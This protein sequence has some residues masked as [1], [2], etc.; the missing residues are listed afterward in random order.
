MSASSQRPIQ[1]PVAIATPH[2]RYFITRMSECYM[3]ARIYLLFQ[4]KIH[5]Y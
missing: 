2:A 4:T 1:P 3:H 5:I